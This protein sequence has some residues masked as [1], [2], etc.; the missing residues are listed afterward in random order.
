MNEISNLI[1]SDVE[2]T[3]VFASNYFASISWELTTTFSKLEE[4]NLFEHSL[5]INKTLELC[6]YL[7]NKIVSKYNYLYKDI[8]I[9]NFKK[10]IFLKLQ[11]KMVTQK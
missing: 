3:Y 5:D 1:S 8:N 9:E 2:S 11:L 10:I 6:I 4:I 7:Q